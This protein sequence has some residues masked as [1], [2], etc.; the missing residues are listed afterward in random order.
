MEEDDQE[1]ANR[2]ADD[3]EEA[4]EANDQDNVHRTS[5]K[6]KERAV[7]SEDQL[8]EE[9]Q[10]AD[11]VRIPKPKT[12]L[13][14]HT[15]SERQRTRPST[16]T[17]NSTNEPGP[18]QTLIN[19]DPTSQL[20][21][22]DEG[23]RSKVNTPEGSESE[24]FQPFTL[25]F[26][27][28]IPPAGMRTNTSRASA[29]PATVEEPIYHN[30]R[31]RAR[32]RSASVNPA[33]APAPDPSTKRAERKPKVRT[34]ASSRLL[35]SLREASHEAEEL[36]PEHEH[37][38]LLPD[39]QS[40]SDM[41]PNPVGGLQEA[42]N[43]SDLRKRG[44]EFEDEESDDD[45]QVR[46]MLENVGENESAPVE[47]VVETPP[48]RAR[49]RQINNP[50]VAP[51]PGKPRGRPKKKIPSVASESS[52]SVVPVD[53]TRASAHKK[54][55]TEEETYNSHFKPIPGTEAAR[56]AERMTAA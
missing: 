23:G 42:T 12:E 14:S 13:Q 4:Y 18:S 1:E 33:P 15:R 48:R 54:K 6:G 49:G 56:Q 36:L 35:S 30:T 39:V 38:H 5:E 9:N 53:G 50:L 32:S 2:L 31:S 19:I 7:E 24:D 44:R 16:S 41:Q 45:R 28:P 17:P 27:Q 46:D 11:D 8:E 34:T 3:E 25:S 55:R 52:S 29:E 22:Q 20:V 26:E 37:E 43:V 51:V 21:R 10:D 40:H 47:V